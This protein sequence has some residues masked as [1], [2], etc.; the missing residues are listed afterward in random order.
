MQQKTIFFAG[1]CFWCTEAIFKGVH[2]VHEVLPGYMGGTIK[3]PA[4]REICTG[5]TGHAE[6]VQIR[7][8]SDLVSLNDLL[9]I[10]FKTHDPTTLNRQGYDVGTQYRSAIFF[11]EAIQKEIIDEV[12]ELLESENVFD[13]PIVTQV[14]EA[15][16]FYL[17]EAEHIDYYANHPD[18][19]YCNL[20]IRPKIEKLREQFKNHLK[21]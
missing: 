1:G 4:Y 3:N 6:A 18:Q 7:Y 20:V 5:R 11:T 9:L 16:P 15:P 13:D 14:V 2:G 19:R 21:A 12:M 17:A 10:F 8:D